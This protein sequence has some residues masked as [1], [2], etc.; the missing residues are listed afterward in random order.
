MTE[1]RFTDAATVS[2]T[3][4]TSDGYLVAEAFAVRTGIQNYAGSEVGL[5]D[6]DV[7][8]VYR[9]ESEVRAADSLRTFSH[10]PITIGHPDKVDATNWRDLAV[11][12]VSTEAEW[13]GNKI[14]LPLIVKDA[15]AIEAIQGGTRELSAGYTCQLEFADGVTPEGEKYDA[16]QRNIRINHLA[17]VPRG[18]AG[19]EFRIGDG[20]VK[21]GA[22]PITTTSNHK[23]TTMSDALK[24]VVLGDKVAHVAVADAQLIEQFKTD[25][26]KALADAA[27]AHEATV[28]AKD[29]EIAKLEAAKD[30]AEKKVLSDA[31]LDKRVADRADLIS[32]AK[33]IVADVKTEGLSDAAI[34]KAVVVAKLG[35]AMADK[36]DAYI[37]ARFDILAE[38]AANG[39][40]FANTMKER[41]FG[42]S[43]MNVADKAYAENV[44]HIETAWMGDKQKGA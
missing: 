18:R 41:P 37:D 6:R 40:A 27:K 12:E 11:G 35:D 42:D 2:G 24:P 25:T 43:D 30:A 39:D 32:K 17:I 14:K 29:A 8:R 38:D 33:T 10:A 5:A 26:A 7:V 31:D 36:S 21:W 22:A 20:A 13:D 9:P 4:V 19:S 34:R 15:G 28:A 3:R 16:I 1:Q 44:T 23:E